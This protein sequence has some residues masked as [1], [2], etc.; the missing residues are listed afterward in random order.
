MGLY[1]IKELSYVGKGNPHVEKT[2]KPQTSLC[3]FLV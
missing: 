2:S 1:G 3:M